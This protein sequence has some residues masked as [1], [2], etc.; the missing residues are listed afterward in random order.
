MKEE[1]PPQNP[2]I[3]K[4]FAQLSEGIEKP[5]DVD[6][7]IARLADTISPV[8]ASWA[9]MF[10]AAILLTLLGSLAL[11][12]A[13]GWNWFATFLSTSASGWAQAIGG[14]LT[15]IAAFRVGRAQINATVALANAQQAESDL[16]MVALVDS[17]LLYLQGAMS[18]YR[19]GAS[20]DFPY[21]PAGTREGINES[22][23]LLRRLDL[24]KCPT[25]ALAL[26]VQYAVGCCELFIR[27]A[28]GREQAMTAKLPDKE[29]LEAQK[30]VWES[31]QLLFTAAG[32]ARKACVLAKQS[33]ER[34]GLG[35]GDV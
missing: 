11:I 14:V 7:S 4:L 3:E 30:A 35:V 19:L 16:R 21:V 12:A 20:P 23:A 9:P 15:V 5:V 27:C 6:L 32:N 13:G 25:A 22:S 8:D 33:I 28:E 18:L 17:S 2:A 1:T 24:F 31:G 26:S 10:G 34:R 29:F